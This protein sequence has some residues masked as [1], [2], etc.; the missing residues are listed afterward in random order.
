MLNTKMMMKKIFY[1][2]I[3]ETLWKRVC[4]SAPIVETGINVNAVFLMQLQ[5]DNLLYKL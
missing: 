4:V 5:G 2:I 1:V 3:A